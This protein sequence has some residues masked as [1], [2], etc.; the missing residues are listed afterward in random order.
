MLGYGT[1]VDYFRAFTTKPADMAD[2]F[3]ALANR[4]GIEVE[5]TYE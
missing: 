1:T 4:H 5:V 2:R 3:V